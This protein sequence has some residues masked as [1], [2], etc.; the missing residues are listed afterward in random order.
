MEDALT[1]QAA[2]TRLGV[3]RQRIHQMLT[4]GDLDG[5]PQTSGARAPRNAPRVFVSSLETWEAGRAGQRRGFPSISEAMFRDD[6]HRMKLA[7][8]IARDQLSKQRRQSE[9]LIGL[10]ADAVA[11][12][13]T[14]QAM[15]R[16]AERI[17]EEYAAIATNH[18]AP[19]ISDVP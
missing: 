5:P 12:L 9:R 6:A 2:A 10:L 4:A 3:S 7:L 14:E 11:A 1:I 16:E 18:L 8:D 17:T 15:A 13:Q 19:D